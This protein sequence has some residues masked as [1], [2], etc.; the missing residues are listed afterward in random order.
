VS[1]EDAA[2]VAR[3]LLDEIETPVGRVG[4]DGVAVLSP[5]EVRG[6]GFRLVIVADLAE[7]GF[8]GR[9]PSDTVLLDAERARLAA[10]LDVS[11][12]TAERRGALAPALLS[13][14]LQAARERA[15]LVLPRLDAGTGS[16]RLPSRVLLEAASAA[17]GDWVDA[18]EIE[19]GGAVSELIRRV[20]ASAIPQVSSAAA[21]DHVA[22][23]VREL[24][25]ALL[26]DRGSFSERGRAVYLGGLLGE[27][28]A[29]RRRAALRSPHGQALTPFDGQVDPVRARAAVA[30]LLATPIGPTA[31]RSYIDCPFGFF[32]RYLLGITVDE[33][34]GLTLD[35]EPLDYGTLAHD[36]LEQLYRRVADDAALGRDEAL[37][38]LPDLVDER[39]RRAER[40][41]LTGYPLA[42]SV[43]RRQLLADL[44][45]AVATD[46]VWQGQMRPAHLEWTFGDA[47]TPPLEFEVDG[48]VVR[49]S[50]RADRIDLSV[51]GAAAALIDYKTGKGEAED[52][53]LKRQIDIQLRVYSLAAA[54]LTPPP[55]EVRASYRLVTRKGGFRDLDLDEG[56]GEVAEALR[57]VVGVVLSRMRAGVFPRWRESDRRCSYCDYDTGCAAR[58]WVFER[59]LGDERLAPLKQLKEGV[60]VASR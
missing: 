6:L 49:F 46:P 48:S 33:E 43:K 30:A 1:L 52:A 28:G 37:A 51:D 7:G 25:L 45:R 53:A 12:E 15:V 16:P 59:K 21:R 18:D 38:L 32:A 20:P 5:Y 58:S 34:P 42:W 4:R 47:A 54:L 35:I 8:P 31:L 10:A 41:G 26:L 9:V 40:D 44:T 60:H 3:R 36:I 27:A 22:L 14:A 56:G 39:A 19:R 23:D 50:G 11:L 29:A 2:S 13:L 17:A 57:A 55:A 24:D